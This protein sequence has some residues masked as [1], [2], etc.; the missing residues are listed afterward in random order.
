MSENVNACVIESTSKWTLQCMKQVFEEK[1]SSL[2]NGKEANYF[3]GRKVHLP[4]CIFHSKLHIFL[5]MIAGVWRYRHIYPILHY[6]ALLFFSIFQILPP[7]NADG[8][9]ITGFRFYD[10]WT[11]DIFFLYLFY[12]FLHICLHF[13]LN[14]VDGSHSAGLWCYYSRPLLTQLGGTGDQRCIC[15]Y[16]YIYT[17]IYLYVNTFIYL[18]ISI[19]IYL[20]IGGTGDQII[21]IW[22]RCIFISRWIIIKELL[23]LLHWNYHLV[24]PFF[25]QH[26]RRG[27]TAGFRFGIA[28]ISFGWVLKRSI[29]RY[30]CRWGYEVQNV[31][32]IVSPHV[33]KS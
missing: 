4:F 17:F 8:R 20:Y 28:K 16:L 21:L 5:H 29:K 13:S 33:F 25:T 30:R 26:I 9:R 1:K 32:S 3:V 10:Y 12:L 27:V 19:F 24:L 23:L 11:T 22:Q 6:F 18:F 15:I 31:C 14:N 2:K 7:H